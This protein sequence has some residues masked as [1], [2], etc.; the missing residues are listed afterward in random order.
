VNVQQGLNLSTGKS[1][2]NLVN[3][4]A[5]ECSDGRKRVVPGSPPTSYL[6]QKLTGVNMCSGS[7]M[8]KQGQGLPSAQTQ[9]IVNWICSGAPNN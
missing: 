7:Q 9:T 3:V 5:G 8:P 1:Y 6:V 2:S 4:S